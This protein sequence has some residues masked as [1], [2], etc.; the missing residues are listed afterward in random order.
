MLKKTEIL[1]TVKG[2]NK[3]KMK[4]EEKYVIEASNI[5]VEEE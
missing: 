4:I 5:M 3:I 1:Q 2:D